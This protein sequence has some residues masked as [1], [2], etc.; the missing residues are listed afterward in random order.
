[1]GD[2]PFGLHRCPN[3][4]GL[5]FLAD[6]YRVECVLEMDCFV[7]GD[8]GS[9][10]CGDRPDPEFWVSFASAYRFPMDE[11]DEYAYPEFLDSASVRR[12]LPLEP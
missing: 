8:G 1:M 11:V 12:V 6:P 3:G 2:S 5:E 4:F 10:L 9:A 7:G